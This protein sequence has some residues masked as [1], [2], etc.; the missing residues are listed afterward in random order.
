MT[1]QYVWRLSNGGHLLEIF[2]VDPTTRR[3][4]LLLPLKRAKPMT[5]EEAHHYMNDNYPKDGSAV[6][7]A[8][9]ALGGKKG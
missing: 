3:A 6:R 8:A 1:E 4:H 7:A 2:K 5:P 9:E